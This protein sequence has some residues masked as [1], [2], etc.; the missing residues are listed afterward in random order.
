MALT[1]HYIP[2]YKGLVSSSPQLEDSSTIDNGTTVVMSLPLTTTGRNIAF[3][4]QTTTYV[5]ASGIELVVC[6]A[7]ATTFTVTLPVAAAT[8]RRIIVK[9]INK[10]TVELTPN[11][12]D[13]IEGA[14][15]AALVMK[16]DS[17]TVVDYAANKWVVVY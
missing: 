11:G 9:N 13:T 8:G 4:V 7:P 15:K 14:N 2:K 1:E 16:N 5:V 3:T 12:T 10:G 6:N 17:C